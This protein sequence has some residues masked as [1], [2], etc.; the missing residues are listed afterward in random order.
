M[1]LG[2]QHEIKQLKTWEAIGLGIWI[3]ETEY[4]AAKWDKARRMVVVR[5]SVDISP[6]ATGK[7]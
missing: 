3:S 2:I 1:P 5:Q 4:K 6:G 7:N